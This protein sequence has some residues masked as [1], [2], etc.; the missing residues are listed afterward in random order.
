MK[1]VKAGRSVTMTVARYVMSVGLSRRLSAGDHVDHVDGDGRNDD[2]RNLQVVSASDNLRK[3]PAARTTKV[4]R[5]FCAFCAKATI[6]R[7]LSSFNYM[8]RVLFCTCACR[9][10]FNTVSRSFRDK[11]AVAAALRRN[12][13]TESVVTS[14]VRIA[15]VRLR[16]VS[17]DLGTV[18][19]F[20]IRE[21]KSRAKADFGTCRCGARLRQRRRKYCSHECE[22]EEIAA[23]R[24]AP[25]PT[26]A[27]L[28]AHFKCRL[29]YCA[30]GRIYGVSDNAVR[31]WA[32]GYGLL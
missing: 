3:G 14:S 31:K 6:R 17:K 21:D 7:G 15:G 23:S 22:M 26:A 29:S 20:L 11:T 10:K 18:L 9:D 2:W 30:I 28:A 19:A 12:R 16:R 32:R 5:F 13:T 27:E 1:L 4:L 24:P 25:K 8:S